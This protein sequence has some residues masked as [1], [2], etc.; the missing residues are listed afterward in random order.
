M[1]KL[2]DKWYIVGDKNNYI[3]GYYKNVKDKKKFINDSFFRS[4]DSVVKEYC[5][6]II[7]QN[8][9]SEKVQS[10]FQALDQFNKLFK[11]KG[12]PIV[13]P[14]VYHKMME[15]ELKVALQKT[16]FHM[17]YPDIQQLNLE[18]QWFLFQF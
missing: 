1:I 7:R 6:I 17:I 10:L 9:N 4:L 16:G 14:T 2:D 12:N 13:A 15:D 8:L 3:L 18:Q 5:N 11:E